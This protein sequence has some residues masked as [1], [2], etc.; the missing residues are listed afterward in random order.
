M[1]LPL[2]PAFE[3][4]LQIRADRVRDVVRIGVEPSGLQYGMESASFAL[5]A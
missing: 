5:P 3:E 2:P 1:A 4:Q